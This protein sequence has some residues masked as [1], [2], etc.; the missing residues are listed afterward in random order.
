ML[1]SHISDLHLGYSQFSLEEREEDVYQVF[2]EAID[3]SI[4]ERARLIILAAIYFTT[5]QAMRQGDNHTWQHTEKVE[6]KA[7]P[8][9]FCAGRT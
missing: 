6:G 9:S 3:A 8:C 2:H 5:S 4:K 7:D 1:M